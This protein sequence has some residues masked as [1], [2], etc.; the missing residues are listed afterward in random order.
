MLFPSGGVL[1]LP[2]LWDFGASTYFA[3]LGRSSNGHAVVELLLYFL[4]RYELR[5]PRLNRARSQVGEYARELVERSSHNS[6]L[7]VL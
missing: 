2:A 5:P 7:W 3:C 6:R 4:L 1:P